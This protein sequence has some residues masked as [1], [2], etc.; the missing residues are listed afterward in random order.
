MK[1]IVV[2]GTASRV[3]K[4][5][6]ASYILRMLSNR[7]FSF[8]KGKI[9]DTKYRRIFQ[10]AGNTSCETKGNSLDL[11]HYNRLWSALKI[12]I[13][14]EGSCPRHTECDTCDDGYEPFKILTSDDIIREKGKDT[15]RLS[16]AG[17]C[18][19]V[20]LQSDS[21]VE[22]IS[23]EA[24]LACFDKE[25]NLVIEGNSFLRVHDANVAVL[26]ASPSVERI[27][28][29]AELLLNKIDFVVINVHKRHTPEEIEECKERMI[30]LGCDVPF[31]VVN[32]CSEEDYSNQSFIDRIQDI[33]SKS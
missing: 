18:K 1:T 14:H 30:A 12:T 25:H 26:V 2:A 4:T 3:G 27:K 9:V 17:A 5:T 32:P 7:T 6:V 13:R 28:R 22:K 33:L 19:V 16:T 15:D 21:D 8:N 24:A 31:Y 29:S 10:H 23:I 11:C 20:W